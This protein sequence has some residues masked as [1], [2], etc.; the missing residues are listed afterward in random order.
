MHP[1]HTPSGRTLKVGYI[2]PEYFRW[3]GFLSPEKGL[4]FADMPHGIAAISKAELGGSRR[5]LSFSLSGVC[6][7]GSRGHRR[8]SHSSRRHR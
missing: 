5:V 7:A 4:K 1:H 6:R 2:V 3:P 8:H